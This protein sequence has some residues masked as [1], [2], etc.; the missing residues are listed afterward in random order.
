MLDPTK[1]GMDRRDLLSNDICARKNGRATFWIIA[2]LGMPVLTP[3]PPRCSRNHSPKNC[4]EPLGRASLSGS[5]GPA[6]PRKSRQNP[7]V[8]EVKSVVYR[9]AKIVAEGFELPIRFGVHAGKRAV[10]LRPGVD[11]DEPGPCSFDWT[12]GAKGAVLSIRSRLGANPV[13]PPQLMG[14]PSPSNEGCRP[15]RAFGEVE[16]CPAR[17][18]STG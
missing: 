5:L 18:P 14:A 15:G 4:L 6:K 3:R 11:G 9:M 10:F 7:A 1:A 12:C 13:P 17:I 8:A 2:R 16:P